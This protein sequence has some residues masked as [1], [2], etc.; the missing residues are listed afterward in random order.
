MKK[1]TQFL[2]RTDV[3]SIKCSGSDG[4]QKDVIKRYPYLQLY[5]YLGD[6]AALKTREGFV[7]MTMLHH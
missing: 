7:F 3:Y 2:T 5:H 6:K 4:F 1:V